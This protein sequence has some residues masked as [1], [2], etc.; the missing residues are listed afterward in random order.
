MKCTDNNRCECRDCRE[1]FMARS[2]RNSASSSDDRH[3]DWD[4]EEEESG[5]VQFLINRDIRSRCQRDSD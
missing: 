2:M 1:K 4:E 3:Y 5:I